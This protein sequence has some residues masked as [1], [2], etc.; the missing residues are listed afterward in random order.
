LHLTTGLVLPCTAE[1]NKAAAAAAQQAR[2]ELRVSRVQK[3]R[4]L[5]ESDPL[6]RLLHCTVAV[7]FA[8]QLQKDLKDMKAGK[9]FG[10]LAAKWAPTP[11]SKWVLGLSMVVCGSFSVWYLLSRF[12][13]TY[14][15]TNHS[16]YLIVCFF[17]IHLHSHHMYPT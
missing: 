13:E 12:F 10:S 3:V 14:K 7:L 17:F 2:R 16:E 1:R 5:L 8:Q 11:H 15:S 4:Q 6:Y 9:K